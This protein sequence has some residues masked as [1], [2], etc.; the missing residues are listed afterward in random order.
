MEDQLFQLYSKLENLEEQVGKMAWEI[1]SV[2]SEVQIACTQSMVEQPQ[3]SSEELEHT[4]LLQIVK[5]PTV[6]GKKIPLINSDS[7]H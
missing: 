2:K 5:L 3:F 7:L 1:A 6:Q 4:P